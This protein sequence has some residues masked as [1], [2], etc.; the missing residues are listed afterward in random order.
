[1]DKTKPRGRGGGGA[2]AGGPAR[3]A[4]RPLLNSMS[5]EDQ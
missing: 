5:W 3:L 1:M 2:A 4:V